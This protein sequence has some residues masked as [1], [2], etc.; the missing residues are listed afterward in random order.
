LLNKIL[1]HRE[2]TLL[3]IGIIGILSKIEKK[4]MSMQL[5]A[6]WIVGFTDGEGCFHVAVNRHKDIKYG[7]QIQPEFSI[8]QHVQDIHLLYGLKE[9]FQCGTVCVNHGDR[10]Q[11]RVR[12]RNH[13]V[14]IVLPFYEKHTL[15]R[16]RQLEFQRFRE[17]CRLMVKKVHLTEE[18]FPIIVQKA[19][20][21]RVKPMKNLE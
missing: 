4:E 12:N 13:L 15:K 19:K 20:S 8:T 2:L 9:Y 11:W 17:I 6:D 7:F 5:N 1:K 3:P 10:F 16:K 18:G 21:L 14:E